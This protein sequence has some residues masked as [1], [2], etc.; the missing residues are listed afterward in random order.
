M[1]SEI[2]RLLEKAEM[3]VEKCVIC[4]SLD[5]DECED[6]RNILDEIRSKIE[7]LQDK[8]AARKLSV[9]L[10]KLEEELESME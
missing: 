10:D 7:A 1:E 4:G 5:C 8:K 3:I 2:R 9:F 6:A